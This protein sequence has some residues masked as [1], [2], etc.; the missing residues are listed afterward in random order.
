MCFS[1]SEGRY[2]PLMKFAACLELNG[3]FKKLGTEDE[4]TKG[5][6]TQKKNIC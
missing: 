5:S 1:I 6:K 2:C 3:R 4:F